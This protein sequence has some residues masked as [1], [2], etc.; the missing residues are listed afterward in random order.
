MLAGLDQKISAD[1]DGANDIAQ[2]QQ[3]LLTLELPGASIWDTMLAVKQCYAL[4][5]QATPAAGQ[6]SFWLEVPRQVN[7]R[8]VIEPDKVSINLQLGLLD[9]EDLEIIDDDA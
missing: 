8:G 1:V 5:V 9:D 2:L 3:Q 6:D 7:F 4:V